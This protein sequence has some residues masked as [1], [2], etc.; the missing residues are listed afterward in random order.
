[1]AKIDILKYNEYVFMWLNGYL[2]MWDTPQERELQKELAEKAYGDVLVAGYGLGIVQE[3]LLKNP[4]VKSITTLEEYKEDVEKC[5]ELFGKIYGKV[6]IKNFYKY[7]GRKK[8]DCV[9]GDIWPDI[10]AKFLKDYV[11]FEKKSKE[12]LKKNGK[13]LAW[14]QDYFEYLLKNKKLNK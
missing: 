3:Y 4:K 13:I 1:M 7:K 2:W 12:V 9:I 6:I 10:S 8:F 14:G 11:K 5:K